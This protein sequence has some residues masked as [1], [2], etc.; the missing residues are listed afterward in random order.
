M[1]NGSATFNDHEAFE[2]LLDY[3]INLAMR[4]RHFMSIVMIANNDGDIPIRRLLGQTV[5]ECDQFFDLKDESA[6]MMPY[7]SQN[8]ACIA[9]DRFK[10]TCDVAVDLRF[11]IVSYPSDATTSKTMLETA[12]HLLSQ[13]K[14]SGFSVV[15]K[16]K[17]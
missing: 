17:Q 4:Y 9:V 14:Q 5:R 8:E 7:T 13:A 1:S 2:W 15:T 6:I 12:K 10:E 3:Q 16:E 11:S